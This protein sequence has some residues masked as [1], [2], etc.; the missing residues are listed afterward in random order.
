LEADSEKL[1]GRL[2][3]G[4]PTHFTY[5]G[6]DYIF[7]GE[8]GIHGIWGQYHNVRRLLK[9]A[10]IDPGFVAAKRE[11]WVYR[12]LGGRVQWSE[13]GSSLRDSW[14]PAP[15]HYLALFIRPRFLQMLTLRDLASMFRV[16]G[17]LIFALAYDPAGEGAPLQGRTLADF[18]R[19]WSPTLQALFTGLARNF[20]SERPDRVPESGFIAF[21]RFY[22]LLRRDSW[23][24]HYFSGDAGSQVINPLAERIKALGGQ[25]ESGVRVTK[26]E[27]TESGWRVETDRGGEKLNAS[28]VI[29]A[30][31]APAAKAILAGSP[32]LREAIESFTT[33]IAIPTI[34]LRY[35]FSTTPTRGVNAEAG[36]FTGEFTL[37]NFFWLHRFQTDF[38]AW[39][40]Q[41]G[42]C[43]I[44]CHLYGN[45]HG[46]TRLFSEPDAVILARGL[47]DLTRVWSELKGCVIHQT[48]RRNSAVH[49]LFDSDGTGLA[50][51]SPF[52]GL[53]LAGDWVRYPHPSLYLERAVVT[54]LA[55]ANE[56]LGAIGRP[57]AKIENV[58]PAEPPARWIERG[59]RAIRE[60][61]RRHKKRIANQE[62]KI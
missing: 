47:L 53:S 6:Q 12:N 4:T 50:V 31:D 38:K 59:L 33:P 7:Y 25:I 56:A 24:F 62:N 14:L 10:A 11:A 51:Q 21:L 30:V 39:H 49:T 27:K 60:R 32:G 1:G 37:D 34:I 44:E 43:V 3:G 45:I 26:L 8:H 18:F 2:S 52:E 20:A 61:T 46:D 15:F 55:A 9:D 19:G 16:L 35:W 40:T 28:Q 48:I 41:T 29:L 42:G 36:I 5:Q 58:T 57:L 54:G 17:G 23:A 22:T 13:G